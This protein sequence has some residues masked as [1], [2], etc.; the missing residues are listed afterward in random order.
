M[1]IE[2]SDTAKNK[3]PS[4]VGQ[5]LTHT[6]TYAVGLVCGAII[7]GTTGTKHTAITVPDAPASVSYTF[8]DLPYKC[9]A[10]DT[11]HPMGVDKD[12][13]WFVVPLRWLE[14]GPITSDVYKKMFYETGKVL[15]HDNNYPLNS[16]V[17]GTTVEVKELTPEDKKFSRDVASCFEGA[18]KLYPQP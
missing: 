18:K 12:G 17:A 3:S 16:D 1:T 2:S 14:H 9:V 5:V 7:A 11:W 13:K 15:L 6:T 4:I 8:Q 10:R